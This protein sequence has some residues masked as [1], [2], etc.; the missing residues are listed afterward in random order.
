MN[1]NQKLATVILVILVA[2]LVASGYFIYKSQ[3]ED[4]YG[5]EPGTHVIDEGYEEIVADTVSYGPVDITDYN[6]DESERDTTLLTMSEVMPEFPGGQEGLD[7]FLG[8]NL[9]YPQLAKEQG[10]QG[11]V[12]ISF[13][14]YKTGKVGNVK[15][16]KGIGGGCDEEAARVI[17]KMPNWKP[18]KQ[19]GKPVNVKFR[20]PINFTLQ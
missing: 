4:Y 6:I 5:Y 2:V 8:N 12:W 1:R 7:E 14:V 9:E 13:I 19:D 10:I 20:F 3:E 18:G 11:K 16:E 17:K 15:V